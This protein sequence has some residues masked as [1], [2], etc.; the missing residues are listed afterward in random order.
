VLKASSGQ[1]YGG[2]VYERFVGVDE[3]ESLLLTPRPAAK[4]EHRSTT[5]SDYSEVNARSPLQKVQDPRPTE[6]PHLGLN[7]SRAN[8][9]NRQS[10]PLRLDEGAFDD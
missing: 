8:R 5:Q 3:A 10:G 6:N 7:P 9:R 1:P 4:F 2:L